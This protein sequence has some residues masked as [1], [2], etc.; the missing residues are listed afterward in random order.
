MS[1]AVTRSYINTVAEVVNQRGDAFAE[2]LGERPP[3][4]GSRLPKSPSVGPSGKKS[5]QTGDG[6]VGESSKDPSDK[7]KGKQSKSKT[8]PSKQSLTMDSEED[9][10][11]PDMQ[12]A[13]KESLAQ[14]GSPVDD[15]GSSGSQQSYPQGPTSAQ[16]G[17]EA[18]KSQYLQLTKELVRLEVESLGGPT[19]QQ[20]TRME[21][22]RS[23]MSS[24][25]KEIEMN[26]LSD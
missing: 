19:F 3:H 4:S 11:D 8:K 20:A 5:S 25:E 15:T 14:P 26:I 16:D 23:V 18:V 7:S 21:A 22:V 24:L 10:E 13:I 17:A 6:K 12:Q 2:F 9:D 1:N